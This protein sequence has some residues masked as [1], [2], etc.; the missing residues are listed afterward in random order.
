MGSPYRFRYDTYTMKIPFNISKYPFHFFR[1]WIAHPFFWALFLLGPTLNII[2]ADVI[3]ERVIY[4]GHALPY[5]I[6]SMMFLPIIFYTGVLIVAISTAFLG[7]VFCGWVCPHNIMSEWTRPIRAAAGIE[8]KTPWMMRME[9]RSP[10]FKQYFKWLAPV[11]AISMAVLMSFFLFHYVLP[12]DYMLGGYL[13]GHPHPT[14][15]M[16]QVIFTLLGLFFVYSG[17]YFCKSCCPYGL[18]QSI[19]AYQT[20]KW[21]PMEIHYLPVGG[22]GRLF[23]SIPN[24]EGD[25]APLLE[26]IFTK[27]EWITDESKKQ[28]A[29]QQCGGCTGCQQVCPVDIDP[30]GPLHVG[31]FEG[32]YN[33]GECID[34]CATIQSHKGR[35]PLLAFR[36]PFGK[37][38]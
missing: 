13:S 38:A 26:R 3:N 33:C 15:V 9:R 12:Y 19:S 20:G 21:R 8:P 35:K 1:P 29:E 23:E 22:N 16:G 27:P 2:R 25:D 34:A 28:T 32:C 6:G 7:R 14:L 37:R 31:A 10:L 5:S 24:Q 36:F 11:L 17:H 18:A 4:L 30:R